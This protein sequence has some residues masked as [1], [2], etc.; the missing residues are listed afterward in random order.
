M[1]S[2]VSKVSE[3]LDS[4]KRTINC[5]AISRS[6]MQICLLD[7]HNAPIKELTLLD[8]NHY[9]PVLFLDK[10]KENYI[11]RGYSALLNNNH[12]EV[13]RLGNEFVQS[14][15]NP[16]EGDVTI[17]LEALTRM[18]SLSE[19]SLHNKKWKPEVFESLQRYLTDERCTLQTL[20]LKDGMTAS[21]LE[22]LKTTFRGATSLRYYKGAYQQ[23]LQAILDA[24][25]PEIEET[26]LFES[27]P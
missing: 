13:L 27:R 26:I 7:I 9:K 14:F 3:I 15:F 4:D 12:I 25:N 22:Q 16:G 10:M 6:A 18:R 21:D 19:L 1:A 8:F 20:E 5:G 17:N 11:S 2:S 23:E 24:K